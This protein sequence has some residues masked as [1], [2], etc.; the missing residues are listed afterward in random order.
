MG[1]W[2]SG[3]T[4]KQE[5]GMATE[6]GTEGSHLNRGTKQRATR[7]PY[8]FKLSKPAPS[9]IFLLVRP[10][11]RNLPTHLSVKGCSPSSKHILLD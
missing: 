3:E 8:F 10:Y 4:W 6:A 2:N 1:I 11:L 5:A 9:N 7:M